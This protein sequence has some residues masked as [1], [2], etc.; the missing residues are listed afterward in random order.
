MHA[1]VADMTDGTSNTPL[2]HGDA[3]RPS[4]YRVGRRVSGAAGADR[5]NEFITHGFTRTWR[6]TPLGALASRPCRDLPTDGRESRR[7]RSARGRDPGA[8]GRGGATGTTGLAGYAAVCETPGEERN[9]EEM[10]QG[11]AE[12]RRGS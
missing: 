3:R 2:L 10:R 6:P 8:P 9:P 1:R 7:G 4:P 5:E 12:S 11:P